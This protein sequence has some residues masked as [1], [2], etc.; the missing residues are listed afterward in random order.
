MAVSAQCYRLNPK[1]AGHS[2][3]LDMYMHGLIAVETVEEEAI[4]TGNVLDRWHCEILYFIFDARQAGCLFLI[5][6]DPAKRRARSQ[7]GNPE[8]RHPL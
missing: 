5:G 1:L 2:A 3:P 8:S 7:S 6:P 4:G